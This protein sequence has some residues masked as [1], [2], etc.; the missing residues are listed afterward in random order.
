LTRGCEANTA[1]LYEPMTEHGY[2]RA[3]S[4]GVHVMQRG[5]TRQA[6]Q[7][8]RAVIANH[9]DQPNTAHDIAAESP[10][11]APPERVR[12]LLDRRAAVVQRRQATYQIWQTEVDSFAH[13]VAQALERHTSRRQDHS[14]DYGIAD[15]SRPVSTLTQ[16]PTAAFTEFHRWWR[17]RHDAGRMAIVLM[18]SPA[19][20]C[21]DGS[22]ALS[23]CGLKKGLQDLAEAG[24]F[25]RIECDRH[26][27]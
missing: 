20:A 2:R 3:P 4:D 8:A 18:M 15:C 12:S 13:A 25:G 11:A 1:Y 26:Q 17:S 10:S 22:I 23:A 16:F 24:V 14:L 5:R 27:W 7:L 9:G 19:W 6:A 21:S